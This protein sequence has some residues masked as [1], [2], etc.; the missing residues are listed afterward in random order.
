MF[1]VFQNNSKTAEDSCNLSLCCFVLQSSCLS[2]D[3]SPAVIKTDDPSVRDRACGLCLLDVDWDS[4]RS[5]LSY[6]GRFYHAAC[7]N[8]WINLVDLTL[9]ALSIPELL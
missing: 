2:L 9:P 4:S 5:K 1:S 8:F 3:L 6:G 7:A